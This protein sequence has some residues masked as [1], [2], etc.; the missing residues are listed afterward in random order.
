MSF[1]ATKSSHIIPSW[2]KMWFE[3]TT[4]PE[5]RITYWASHQQ[6]N[7]ILRSS[8]GSVVVGDAE[9]CVSVDGCSA[10]VFGQDGREVLRVRMDTKD[11]ARKLRAFYEA[12]LPAHLTA[13]KPNGL[14][15]PRRFTQA[16]DITQC[17]GGQISQYLRKCIQD[18]GTI[19]DS[20]SGDKLNILKQCVNISVASAS[21]KSV[22]IAPRY[23]CADGRDFDALKRG[24][25][26]LF[27]KRTCKRCGKKRGEHRF[28]EGG[29]AI[30]LVRSKLNRE[31]FATG[32]EAK[33]RIG[34]GLVWVQG[35][36]LETIDG[37]DGGFCHIDFIGAA[38][39]FSPSKD[40]AVTAEQ[41]VGEGTEQD[42][43]CRDQSDVLPVLPQN[44][45]FR[46]SIQKRNGVKQL[47]VTRQETG[48][49]VIGVVP[50]Y[51]IEVEVR[52]GERRG[53]RGVLNNTESGQLAP[54][55]EYQV[56]C[57][58][59]SGSDDEARQMVSI[60]GKELKVLTRTHTGYALRRTVTPLASTDLI[61]QPIILTGKAA[62]GK[63]TFTKQYVYDTARVCLEEESI[64]QVP[65]KVT[66]IDFAQVIEQEQRKNPNLNADDDLLSLY[67]SSPKC[68]NDES[69]RQLLRDM[70][71][72]RRLALLL[73]GM[74]EAGKCRELIEAYVSCRLITEVRLCVTA[75]P[76]GIAKKKELFDPFFV[77]VE[78]CDLNEDQQASIIRARFEAKPMEGA[79]ILSRITSF[80]E[81]VSTNTS[82]EELAKN[83]LLLN[84]MVSEFMLHERD[85][86]DIEFTG[87]IV[88]GQKHYVASFPGVHKRE[89]DRVTVALAE[90]SVACVYLPENSPDYGVHVV[91]ENDKERRCYCQT[92]L[93]PQTHPA[94]EEHS[95]AAHVQRDVLEFIMEEG[96]VR[97]SED[98]PTAGKKIEV[99]LERKILYPSGFESTQ[100]QW[101][102]CT[103]LCSVW[104]TGGVYS[105]SIG[106]LAP[107]SYIPDEGNVIVLDLATTAVVS[108]WNLVHIV[109]GDH[110]GKWG[111]LQPPVADLVTGTTYMVD[112]HEKDGRLC[113]TFPFSPTSNGGDKKTK[114]LELQKGEIYVP[115]HNIELLSR[116]G[117]LKVK[118]DGLGRNR[119]PG[120]VPLSKVNQSNTRET[121]QQPGQAPFGCK[122]FSGWKEE[123]KKA[124]ADNQIAEIVFK[125]GKCGEDSF[126]GLGA[127][128]LK[129]V[130]YLQ[131]AY[132]YGPVKKGSGTYNGRT[133]GSS[134]EFRQVDATDFEAENTLN[135]AQIYKSATD[136]LI[137]KHNAKHLA[138]G[139]SSTEQG[140]VVSF[141]RILSHQLMIKNGDQFRN[142]DVRFLKENVF[143]IDPTAPAVWENLRS[144]IH[145]S[146]FALIAWEPSGDSDSY[147]ISHLS[148]QE[149][150]SASVVAREGVAADGWGAFRKSVSGDAEYAVGSLVK[151][152]KFLVTTE[153]CLELL[154]S[155]DR[156]RAE[157]FACEMLQP[158][159]KGLVKV[160]AVAAV[161][162]SGVNTLLVLV[163][164]VA[165]KFQLHLEMRNCA[166]NDMAISA[167]DRFAT[168]GSLSALTG[169]NLSQ[170]QGLG[171]ACGEFDSVANN[172]SSF[173]VRG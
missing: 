18:N 157:A 31:T 112:V 127:S 91:D 124:E 69:H 151:S 97:T 145:E 89:W 105:G 98:A 74:D 87:R 149:Y 94:G 96:D 70:H 80:K 1:V 84:L 155:S 77:G 169:L 102:V 16:R 35:T 75:R 39:S 134:C 115:K 164:A 42:L 10:R 93:Y 103:V 81:Q 104:V 51:R 13:R 40:D 62:S 156:G 113:G 7:T 133:E 143:T 162:R 68:T 106:H 140:D 114:V 118:F 161:D 57:A 47:C 49:L 53:V 92:F 78:V 139:V 72:E 15:E 173:S 130:L 122:W 126:D 50:K 6:R 82:F 5:R 58:G 36:V 85:G 99:L 3:C 11:Q 137:M 116:P 21:S 44:R 123:T 27:S 135:R 152:S 110:K 17:S 136:G 4:S 56:E 67:I 60:K 170:N 131:K 121:S 52:D 83:P 25:L 45:T 19:E 55:L 165:K 100:S 2:K 86:E 76:Q 59:S 37:N 95:C 28:V 22:A 46:G 125:K 29:D 120:W 71:R 73:D 107:P 148:F 160:E 8:K 101:W 63:S 166:L 171:G 147:R 43:Y 144:H 65:L 30:G 128:Q 129:E 66:V 32:D 12:P 154:Q 146:Q 132:G 26:S 153:M 33:G 64:R 88:K 23:L 158:N 163:G 79:D 24:L 172:N 168:H 117:Y 150:F 109:H 41:L 9:N 14:N 108:D 167:F 90:Q 54:S 48:D 142:F 34:T 141:L 20:I 119:K 159:L 61:S 111:V 38:V 138:T